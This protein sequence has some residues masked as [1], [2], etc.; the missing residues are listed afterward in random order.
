[1]QVKAYGKALLIAGDTK[2]VKEGPHM[3]HCNRV[4]LAT[5][6]VVCG[7]VVVDVI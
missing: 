7:A 6:N 2:P 3:P 4:G 1:L 5:I